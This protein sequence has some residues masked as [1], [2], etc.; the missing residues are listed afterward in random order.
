MKKIFLSFFIII[1]TFSVL[2]IIFSFFKTPT[3][4]YSVYLENA[5]ST[6]PTMDY[7][8]LPTVISTDFLNKTKISL[9]SSKV[10]FIEVDL[11][12]MNLNLYK[13]GELSLSF[14]IQSKGRPGSWWETPIG[15]YKIELKEKTHFSSIGRVYQPWS[16]QFQGNFFI[17]G[18]PY[19]E[20]G[21]ETSSQ[22]TGGCVKLNT[23]DAKSLFDEVITGMP[24]L[25]FNEEYH[26]DSF[27]HELSLPELS[28]NHFLAADLNNDYIFTSKNQSEQVPIASITK[29]MTALVA[30]EYI[31]L[32]KS[33]VVGSSSLVY[34]S[35]PRLTK[36]LSIE[37][38][39][40]LHLLLEESSNE[41]AEVL[42][43]N[44]G[45][46]YFIDLMN[47]KALAIGLKNTTFVDPAGGGNGNIST[48]EDLFMLGK[49]I[50][51]NRSFILKI[52]SGQLNTGINK[53]FIFPNI[54]NFNEF[55]DQSDF[56]GGKVGKTTGAGET[57]ISIFDLNFGGN[58]RSIL[59]ISLGST[60]GK[61]DIIKLKEFVQKNFNQ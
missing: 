22:F 37:S 52:S 30:S 2:T 13:S 38:F 3:K 7:G 6:N 19:Y 35:K 33:L 60:D 34:T 24:V 51:N 57:I 31:N 58:K 46:N 11:N 36:G 49:Y 42:A 17:H 45:R 50:F 53:D 9:I 18:W 21:Q 12:K 39:E 1:V 40:L 25:V 43:N 5:S 55:T 29:L 56:I 59:F 4:V 48:V 16:M 27:K 8:L 54:N 41:S 14:K 15:M 26:K 61:A 28:S 44:I 10:Y 23:L 20:G 47:K 32:G